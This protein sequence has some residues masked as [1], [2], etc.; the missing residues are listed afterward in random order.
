MN[1]WIWPFVEFIGLGFCSKDDI[2]SL[3]V[4]R[5]T[6]ESGRLIR[7]VWT[8][9]LWLSSR[10]VLI[11]GVPATCHDLNIDMT[12]IW[13]KWLEDSFHCKQMLFSTFQFTDR[14]ILLNTH[15]RAQLGVSCQN[16]QRFYWVFPRCSG[17]GLF[18][19]RDRR[20]TQ[21]W[22]RNFFV[23]EDVLCTSYLITFF[24]TQA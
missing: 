10:L 7:H 20:R 6:P 17:I 12:S 24:D 3:F 15:I 1:I 19:N 22:R 23:T 16:N 4:H 11:M 14:P 2:S 8:G 21:L 9:C 18:S 5:E 13:L